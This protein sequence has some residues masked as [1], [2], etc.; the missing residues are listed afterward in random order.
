[1]KSILLEGPKDL[2]VVDRAEPSPGAATALVR[3]VLNGLCG[4]DLAAFRGKAPQIVFPRVLGHEMLVEVEH[5][6]TRPELEG[7]RAVVE[8]I[9]PCGGCRSCRIGRPNCCARLRVLG[10]QVDG[11]LTERLVLDPRRLHPVPQGLADESAVFSEPA[12]VAYHAVQ[13]SGVEA[14][15]VAVVFGAGT[16]GLLITQ[17]LVRARG[18][19]AIVVD[20]D[21]WRLELAAGYGATT[22]NGKDPELAAIVDEATAGEFADVVFEATGAPAATRLV[23]ELAAFGGTVVTVGW[24]P[25]PTTVDTVTLMRKELN[26]LGSRAT[27]G[28]FP[29]VL[30]LLTDGLIDTSALVS[31]VVDFDHAGDALQHLDAPRNNALKVLVRGAQP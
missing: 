25:G 19:R 6:P 23:T 16:I 29:N 22:V 13:R 24:N 21:P 15:Q 1:M 26:F 5:S 3:P 31:R 11:G 8:P 20:L 12:A 7:A 9:V 10:V 28:V 18:C 17:I 27:T 4:S 14:G 30:R 2:R